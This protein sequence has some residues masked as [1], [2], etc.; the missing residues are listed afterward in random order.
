MA[1]TRVQAGL[2]VLVLTLDVLMVVLLWLM[3]MVAIAPANNIWVVYAE[4]GTALPILTEQAIALRQWSAAAPLAWAIL[5]L[6][7]GRHLAGQPEQA[8]CIGL[9]V[10]LATSLLIGLALLLVYALAG[11]LPF[12]NIGLSA[13]P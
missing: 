2:P 9:I 8:R 4:T 3:A 7:F 6:R 10:H 11:I 12:L 5:T 1:A 13:H